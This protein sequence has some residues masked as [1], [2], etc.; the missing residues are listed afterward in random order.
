MGYFPGSGAAL[1][2]SEGAEQLAYCYYCQECNFRE[3]V[4]LTRVAADFPPE[5][6]IG[7]LQTQLPCSQC[8][9]KKKI[10]LL[11]W[12]SATTT[13]TMLAERGFAVWD[14]DD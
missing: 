9:G 6:Q 13:N 4:R 2:L 5:T 11:L 7:D 3:R 10:V 14:D 12:L 8:G 1:T